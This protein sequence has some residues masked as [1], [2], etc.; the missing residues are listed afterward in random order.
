M[1]GWVLRVGRDPFTGWH[2]PHAEDGRAASA[3]M[4]LVAVFETPQDVR[5]AMALV[6]WK[7]CLAGW[8]VPLRLAVTALA[9][10]QM[11]MAL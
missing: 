9:P 11:A 4:E 8:I 1:S 6:G 2:G 7:P 10:H 3:T 5:D